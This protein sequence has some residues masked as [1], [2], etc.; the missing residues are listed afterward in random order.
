MQ[1]QQQQHTV[2]KFHQLVTFNLPLIFAGLVQSGPYLAHAASSGNINNNQLS[3]ALDT[4]GIVNALTISDN[5]GKKR[6]GEHKSTQQAEHP[7]PEHKKKQP[8]PTIELYRLP[9]V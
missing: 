8:Q 4:A 6:S 3:N 2:M 9:S 5:K 1:Q 7:S